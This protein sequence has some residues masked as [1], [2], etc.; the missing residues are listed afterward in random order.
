MYDLGLSRI[1]GHNHGQ[2]E[3]EIRHWRWWAETHNI[4]T[5]IKEQVAVCNDF[6]SPTLDEICTSCFVLNSVPLLAFSTWNISQRC[7]IVFLLPFFSLGPFLLW[8][9]PYSLHFFLSQVF[10]EQLPCAGYWRPIE[11]TTSK[12]PVL[13]AFIIQQ[14]R[15][16]H[17]ATM[18]K[19]MCFQRRVVKA[20]DYMARHLLLLSGE[21]GISQKSP[22]AWKRKLKKKWDK[23]DIYIV[24]VDR[25]NFSQDLPSFWFSMLDLSSTTFK[26][27]I[28]VFGLL[29][30]Y[31]VTVACQVQY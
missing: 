29:N 15:Q 5:I 28:P 20:W 10:L 4:D 2:I 23:L 17:E 18:Q 22:L 11:S 16:N 12:A 19:V 25:M 13:M 26:D 9:P 3:K 27:L 8:P 30:K 24:D 1:K 21:G 7:F 6:K 14:G 31:W